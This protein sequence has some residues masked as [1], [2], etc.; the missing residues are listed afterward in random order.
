MFSYEQMEKENKRLKYKEKL[1]D[2]T[3]K[4]GLLKQSKLIGGSNGI[5]ISDPKSTS[6]EVGRDK[7][8][9]EGENLKKI[10]DKSEMEKPKLSKQTKIGDTMLIVRKRDVKA[11]SKVPSQ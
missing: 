1:F 5:R 2:G 7:L 8:K 10:M 3:T 9:H 4:D 6:I 11:D